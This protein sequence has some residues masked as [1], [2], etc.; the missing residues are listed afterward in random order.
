MRREENIFAFSSRRVGD[1]DIVRCVSA[2]LQSGR[3]F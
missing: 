1:A 3:Y 2:A